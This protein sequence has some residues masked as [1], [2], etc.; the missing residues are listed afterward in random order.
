MNNDNNRTTKEQQEQQHKQWMKDETTLYAIRF[1][2][3]TGVPDALRRATSAT[4]E[5]QAEYLKAS[6]I[7]RLKE[8]GFLTG[9]V[10][11]NLNKERHKQKLERLEQYIAA[12]KEKMK[13]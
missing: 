1:L 2:N 3:S 10:V 13:R 5:T 7:K 12:E 8:E 11:L 4:G 6:I 9:E